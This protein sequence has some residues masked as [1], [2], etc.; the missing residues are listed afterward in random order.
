MATRT[1]VE[2]TVDVG[3]IGVDV[4]RSDH[5]RADGF[6]R[7]RTAP[8]RTGAFDNSSDVFGGMA[9]MSQLSTWNNT[10][11]PA[12][13][14]HVDVVSSKKTE[15]DGHAVTEHELIIAAQDFQKDDPTAYSLWAAHVPAATD[16]APAGL[17]RL[18]LWVDDAGVVWKMSSY[19]DGQEAKAETDHPRSTTRRTP[20]FR[21]T[22][23][24][25]SI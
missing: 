4:A 20:S 12:I 6:G 17:V 2:M 18:I 3:D 21:T 23:P 25:T 15:V 5:R 16:P 10:V 24:S 11:P 8:G 7:R 14:D 1:V 13:R 9:S 22:R 19:A